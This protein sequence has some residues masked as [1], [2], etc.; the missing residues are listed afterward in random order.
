MGRL[1]VALEI[2]QLV[3][4]QTTS[5]RRKE[6]PSTVAGLVARSPAR[7]RSFPAHTHIHTHGVY[8]NK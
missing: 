2:I 3:D 1:H 6:T 5:Q 8:S 4:I 7:H